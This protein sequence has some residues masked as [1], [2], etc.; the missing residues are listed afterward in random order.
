LLEERLRERLDMGRRIRI[1]E[2]ERRLIDSAIYLVDSIRILEAKWA[3]D[4]V[5]R[6]HKPLK[7]GHPGPPGTSLDTLEVKPLLPDSVRQ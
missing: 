7:P 3:L 6:P 2:C 5:A 1:D 4:T